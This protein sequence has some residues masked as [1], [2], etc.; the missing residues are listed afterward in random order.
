MQN[1]FGSGKWAS[2]RGAV[3]RSLD[4]C[5]RNLFL[6]KNFCH[7]VAFLESIIRFSPFRCSTFS[8][9]IHVLVKG[10]LRIL[11]RPSYHPNPIAFVFLP[12]KGG[13]CFLD[14]GAKDREASTSGEAKEEEGLSLTVLLHVAPSCC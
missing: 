9:G 6:L 13:A 2:W 3:L 14:R 1:V 7:P 11:M 12:S 10:I 5:R 4:I 8:T